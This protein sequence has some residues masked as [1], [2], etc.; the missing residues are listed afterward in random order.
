VTGVTRDGYFPY[1]P[2]RHFPLLGKFRCNTCNTR[3]NACRT[4]TSWVMGC[5]T[6]GLMTPSRC[7]FSLTSL[8]ACQ[9]NPSQERVGEAVG[10]LTI[11]AT[12]TAG[13]KIG[14]LG[15]CFAHMAFRGIAATRDRDGLRDSF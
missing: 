2:Y 5:G 15:G 4:G 9:M 11:I 8:I 10:G 3:N 6:G 13:D 14:Q 7:R 12:L 1:T